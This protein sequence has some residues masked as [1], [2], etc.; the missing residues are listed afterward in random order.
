MTTRLSRAVWC[1][2]ALATIEALF[3]VP[4]L[5][6]ELVFSG[7]HPALG[8]FIAFASLLLLGSF[9]WRFSALLTSWLQ[10]LVA[11]LANVS[12]ALF[13]VA[14][15]VVGTA[16]RILWVWHFHAPQKSDQASYFALAQG[17]LQNHRYGFGEGGL[18]YWPPGFPFFLAFCFLVFGV[19][20]WVP[21]LANILLFAGTLV[22]VFRLGSRIGGSRSG[23]LA[24]LLLVPWP[25]FVMI[26]GFSGKEPLLVLLLCLILL[27]FA[28]VLETR[29][30]LARIGLVV[31]VGSLL[32]AASLTQP[33]FLLFVLVLLVYDLI[34]TGRALPVAGRFSLAV[35]S[36][37]L[38]ILPWTFRNH[39]VL[40]AWIPVSTNG[41]D[42]LYRANNPLATG[43]YTARGEVN[44]DG[45]DEVSRGRVGFRLGLEWIRSHPGR[46]AALAVRKQV[47]FLGD[48]GQGAF[49]TLKRGLDIGGF[50]YIFWKGVSNVYWW[51]LWIIILAMLIEK[52]KSALS[53]NPL[54]IATMLA[55]LYLLAIHSVFES[56]AKYHEP[57]I[58]LIAVI[59][60][61]IVA[62]ETKEGAA[63]SGTL[64]KRKEA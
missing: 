10:S 2:F 59:A 32:A 12:P 60:A 9:L 26:A 45:L 33:S 57:L 43:G 24:A 55:F 49:E 23:K 20:G 3:S 35:L 16:L 30:S 14:C 52:C 36:M 63:N 25:T 8:L 51:M 34:C 50:R 53:Q 15:F 7:R 29:S 11:P 48:D 38:V 62:S 56:G 18:A 28:R 1:L 42:V 54:L 6:W 37:S 58:G 13:L 61:Q 5:S 64:D 17:L 21:L 41:G 19:K 4:L 44:L 40:G 31:L 22:V 46:F 47:L 39:R 27:V